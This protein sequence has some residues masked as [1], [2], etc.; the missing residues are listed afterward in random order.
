MTAILF[1]GVLI[2]WCVLSAKVAFSATVGEVLRAITRYTVIITTMRVLIFAF[3][4]SLLIVDEIIGRHQFYSACSKYAVVDL[5]PDIRSDRVYTVRNGRGDS[6]EGAVVPLTLYRSTAIDVEA[7][8][9]LFR[10]GMVDAKGGWLI[11]SLGISNSDTPLL[12][13]SRCDGWSSVIATK[14]KFNL[15]SNRD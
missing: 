1:F 6:I 2:A 15:R 4:L 9:M 12:Y 5:A 14:N 3:L 7:G 10:Y 8:R 11:R 13:P